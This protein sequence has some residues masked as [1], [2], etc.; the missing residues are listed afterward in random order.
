MANRWI[1]KLVVV[2]EDFTYTSEVIA[3]IKKRLNDEKVKAQ[4]VE[5]LYH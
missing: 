1:L 2:S 3:E 5:E 4:Y